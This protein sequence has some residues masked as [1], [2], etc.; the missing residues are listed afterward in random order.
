MIRG[1]RQ[2]AE[3][4]RYGIPQVILVE[5]TEALGGLGVQSYFEIYQTSEGHSGILIATRE[6]YR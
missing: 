2:S 3:Y 1:K 6:L 4:I 5:R